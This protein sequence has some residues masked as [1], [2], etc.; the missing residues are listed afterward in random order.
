MHRQT[1]RGARHV[2]VLVMLI[3][4]AVGSWLLPTYL[5]AT[6]ETYQHP[7]SGLHISNDYGF[8]TY[9]REHGGEHGV[10]GA[11]VTGVL[12]EQGRPV[13]Y[14][15]RGRLEAH[16]DQPDTPIMLGRIGADYADSLWVQFAAG[17]SDNLPPG[18]VFFAETRHTLDEPF[19][20]FW[21]A[22]GGVAMLGFPISEP[23]W[24]HAGRTMI[25][26]QYF[27]RG[28]L[29]RHPTFGSSADSVRVTNM[30]TA[31]AELRGYTGAAAGTAVGA[32]PVA[33]KLNYSAPVL[34]APDQL[35][36]PDAPVA[37][38]PELAPEASTD[39]AA[40]VPEP[41]Y[42]PEPEPMY[43]PEP[44]YAPPPAPVY[45]SGAKRVVVNLSHQWLYAYEGDVQVF[46][47]PVS[48]GRDG[49]NTPTGSFSVYAKNPLQ[50]MSGTLQG[51][52]YSVPDVPNA[53][54]IVGDVAMH[55]TYWH[56]MFGTGVRMSHG[57]INL[58]LDSAAWLYNWAP[59]GTPVQVTY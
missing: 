18:R 29:E 6:S 58:P 24:E 19:L 53:M 39:P 3:G 13:Q 54:Y 8:L 25:E 47:A 40:A 12:E 20:S 35:A 34:R 46:S 23:L 36:P 17:V 33:R 52:Y 41:V 30:G 49:F 45:A 16:L 7:Q 5:Q 42:V 2:G 1:P 28:R 38:G 57:C 55:G 22:Q 15:E 21:Q 48:T 14:F 4:I 43:V 27:E 11:P 50:T 59:V 10:L 37:A 44:V 51:E 32:V 31:L 26:V 56:N 9:W